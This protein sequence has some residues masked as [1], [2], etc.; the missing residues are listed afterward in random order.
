MKD[1]FHLVAPCLKQTSKQNTTAA[2][3]E[4]EIRIKEEALLN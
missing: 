3:K 4:E 2:K 1:T